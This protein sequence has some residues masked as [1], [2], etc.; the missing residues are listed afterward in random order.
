MW[1]LWKRE[2]HRFESN[3]YLL[4]ETTTSIFHN[5]LLYHFVHMQLLFEI[6]Y[7]GIFI[8]NQYRC[9]V[10]QEVELQKQIQKQL[11]FAEIHP[12]TIF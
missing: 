11:H 3:T 12:P 7:L 10:F 1:W 9:I 2:R 5:R 4:S 6:F 8:M